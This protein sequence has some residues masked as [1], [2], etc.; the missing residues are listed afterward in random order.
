MMRIRAGAPADAAALLDIYR[1]YVE[2]TAISFELVTPS[3]GEFRAR[4]DKALAGW[5]WLVAEDEGRCVGYAYGSAH[6]AREAYR[7]STEVSA[8]VHPRHHRRGVARLLYARLFDSLA[9]KGYCAAFAGVALPN[10]ASVGLHGSVGFAP[11]GVFHAVGRKFDRW[12]DVAW[13]ER[14]LRDAPISG[15]A[16]IDSARLDL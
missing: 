15:A 3:E 7:Y 13:F 8:Y 14:K 16:A 9:H 11:V 12:H 10:E 6:R 4:I 5:D 2:G 1:P